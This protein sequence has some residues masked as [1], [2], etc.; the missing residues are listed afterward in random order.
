MGFVEV[1]FDKGKLD[2]L[3]GLMRDRY[4]ADQMAKEIGEMSAAWKALRE[5]FSIERFC[6]FLDEFDDVFAPIVDAV[7]TGTAD[8]N[9][10]D[11][12]EKEEYIV[13]A[14]GQYGDDLIKFSGAGGLVMEMVD[15][16]LIKMAAT[17]I[18]VARRSLPDAT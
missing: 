1:T 10:V 6:T 14:V 13:E 3:L 17:R 15:K 16:M 8:W 2:Q 12:L 9:D 18:I 7:R 5:T 4:S 11:D